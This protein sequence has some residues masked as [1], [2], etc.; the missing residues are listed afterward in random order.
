M[1]FFNQI[2]PVICDKN[3]T[4]KGNQVPKNLFLHV[5]AGISENPV[6]GSSRNV[7]KNKA[8]CFIV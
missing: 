3:I 5:F 7:N 8:F 4:L 6:Q 1:W 2:Y